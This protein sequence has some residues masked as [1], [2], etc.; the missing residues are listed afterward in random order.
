MQTADCGYADV[1]YC[2]DGDFHDAATIE[3]CAARGIL[4]AA[5]LA[6]LLRDPQGSAGL[7]LERG[8]SFSPSAGIF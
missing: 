5:L 3:F 4:E 1:L 2:N 7:W 6:V 8:S